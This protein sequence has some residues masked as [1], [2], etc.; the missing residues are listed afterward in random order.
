MDLRNFINSINEFEEN[1]IRSEL[2]KKQGAIFKE[3][4]INGVTSAG[5][6]SFDECSDVE[7]S[8]AKYKL[9]IKDKKK[10]LKEK[11]IT[12]D[13]SAL[14]WIYKKNLSED[15]FRM[16]K[17]LS[18][19]HKY[20]IA[21]HFWYSEL[22]SKFVIK[23]IDILEI[24]GGAC[25]LATI[26]NYRKLINTYT[27][28]DLPEML[29]FGGMTLEK[30][31]MEP[32]FEQINNKS[33]RMLTPKTGLKLSGKQFDFFLNT[34]SMSEMPIK[35]INGY[36]KFAKK[37][38][39]DGSLWFTINR[40]QSH[41]NDKDDF[42]R[43]NPIC[44]DWPNQKVIEFEPDHMQWFV[45]QRPFPKKNPSTPMTRIAAFDGK[46]KRI[47]DFTRNTWNLEKSK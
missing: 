2:W 33:I 17:T 43:V 28:I 35:V 38:S 31:G 6:F 21:R 19:K 32:N 20:E 34:N 44:W 4:L 18:I 40:I 14:I 23:P 5:G 3:K 15:Y 9:T 26:L 16:L 1:D 30:Y 45:M 13:E 46:N 11:S 41:L 27:N 25:T 22:I 8:I 37:T 12:E 36:I 47:K 24:G 29:A 39:R 10:Y 7:D 42:V